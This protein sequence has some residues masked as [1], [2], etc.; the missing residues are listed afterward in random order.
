MSR[1]DFGMGCDPPFSE[2]K[3]SLFHGPQ[4]QQDK[5]RPLLDLSATAAGKKGGPLQ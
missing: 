3:K 1:Y 4:Q 5:Q 2:A